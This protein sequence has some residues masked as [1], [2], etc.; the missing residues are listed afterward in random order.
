LRYEELAHPEVGLAWGAHDGAHGIRVIACEVGLEKLEY[1]AGMKVAPAVF[2]GG[3]AAASDGVEIPRPTPTMVPAEP[4]PA[5][6]WLRV[7]PKLRL[8]A[9]TP[10]YWGAETARYS[11]L[12]ATW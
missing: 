2:G 12:C 6:N 9:D 11:V 3:T 4:R 8:L 1:A 7:V 10:V 5:R